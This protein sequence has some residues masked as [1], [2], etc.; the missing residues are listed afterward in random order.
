[1][2]FFFKAPLISLLPKEQETYKEILQHGFFL[3]KE[4]KS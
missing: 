4:A 3:Q 2:F 1:M